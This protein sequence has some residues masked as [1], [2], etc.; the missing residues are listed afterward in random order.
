MSDSARAFQI[1]LN[2][3]PIVDVI[4]DSDEIEDSLIYLA[5]VCDCGNHHFRHNRCTACG[6]IAPWAAKLGC[7]LA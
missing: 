2:D 5:D 6:S 3:E 4:D 1:P 7:G